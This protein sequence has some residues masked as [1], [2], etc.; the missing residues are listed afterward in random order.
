VFRTIRILKGRARRNRK[1][2]NA[3]LK[4]M[5]VPTLISGTETWAVPKKIKI[6]YGESKQNSEDLS[7]SLSFFVSVRYNEE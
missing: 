3:L 7:L 4:I 6:R 5:G 1:I 2:T